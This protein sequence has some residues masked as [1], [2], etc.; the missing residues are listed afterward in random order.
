MTKKFNP[1]FCQIERISSD[2]G[3]AYWKKWGKKGDFEDHFEAMKQ[4]V[5]SVLKNMLAPSAGDVQIVFAFAGQ[6]ALGEP[7]A[8]EK[9]LEDQTGLRRVSDSSKRRLDEETYHPCP[10]VVIGPDDLM[11]VMGDERPAY[12]EYPEVR[13]LV[14]HKLDP[15]F[16][17]FDSSIWHRYVP[18]FPP[19]DFDERLKSTVQDILAYYRQGLYETIVAQ[20][21]LEYDCRILRESY[22]LDLDSGHAKSVTPHRFHAES[23]MKLLAD[24]AMEELGPYTWGCL[25][26]DDYFQEPLRTAKNTTPVSEPDTPNKT[27]LIEALINR[28]T[29]QNPVVKILNHEEAYE[30]EGWINFG[31]Q[32]LKKYPK[33]DVVMLDYFLGNDAPSPEEQFGYELIRKI[34]DP[35]QNLNIFKPFEKFW[36]FPISVFSGSFSNHLQLGGTHRIN[37]HIELADGVDPVNTPELFRYLFYKFLQEQKMDVGVNLLDLAEKIDRQLKAQKSI[38]KI[39]TAHYA[40][41][42]FLNSKL[43]TIEK[44]A[45]N[46]KS[47]LRGSG[48]AG[49]DH[50]VFARHY[51]VAVDKGRVLKDLC[52]HLQNLAYLVAFGSGLEWAK[53]WKSYRFI[54]SALQGMSFN[55]S[56]FQEGVSRGKEILRQIERYILDLKSQ[57]K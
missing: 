5:E 19:T 39:L 11:E 22:F 42:T 8:Y 33:A 34:Q 3:N 14:Q 29:N 37:S 17:F 56:Q 46:R 40:E 26:I 53:M 41:I 45:E 52:I 32:L 12:A 24:K 1:E 13:T 31:E 47:N 55:D 15:R 49:K 38:R 36:I 44:V 4:Q 28:R 35:Q 23:K 50:S 27:Q 30:G 7:K 21:Y 2:L 43:A 54:Q 6:G 10:I 20:E 9:L 51:L 16:R 48:E 25:L 57:Y 18:V